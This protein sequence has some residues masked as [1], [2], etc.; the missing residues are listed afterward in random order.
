MIST[1]ARLLT[2]RLRRVQRRR[3]GPRRILPLR[4]TGQTIT[5]RQANLMNPRGTVAVGSFPPNDFGLHDVCR[6][7]WLIRV[8]P[9]CAIC[10]FARRGGACRRP[11]QRKCG[12]PAGLP[13]N[14]SAQP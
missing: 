4:L 11:V 14:V 3:A 10:K 12:A 2:V 8:P 6:A 1:R 7:A 5:N 9:K 13:S